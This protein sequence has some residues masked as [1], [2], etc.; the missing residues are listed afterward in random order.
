MD[1][2]E[3]KFKALESK[4]DGFLAPAFEITVGRHKID[5]AKIPISSLEVTI[6]AGESAGGCSFEIE[7]QYDYEKGSWA[8]DLLDIIAVGEKLII[9][10]GY[11][12]KKEIFYGF[13]DDVVIDYSADAAPRIQVNGIDAKGLLMGATDNKYMSEKSATA[14]VKEILGDCVSKGYAKKMTVGAITDFKA[15]LIQEEMDDYKFLCKLAEIYNVCFMV[16]DGEII[17]EN[18]M[19]K[20]KLLLTL[21]LGVNLLSFRKA[22][23]VKDQVGKVTVYSVDPTTLEAIEGSAT[24]TSISG[25]GEEAGDHAKA[26]DSIVEKEVNY[27]VTTPEECKRLAQAQFDAKAFSF[28]AGSGRCLGIPELIPGRYIKIDGLDKKSS[29]QYFISKVTHEY[30]SENGYFTSFEVKGAKSK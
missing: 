24:D 17:F 6:E 1:T 27:F 19:Q 29:D 9:K 5:S 7:S 23:S 8:D 26:F 12:S 13:V 11:V 22:L 30:S 10:G 16:I 2:A 20:T 15:Q 14:I 28:V 4:Y 25:S 21:T 18:L 3:Y